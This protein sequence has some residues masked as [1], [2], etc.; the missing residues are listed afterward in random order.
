[1]TIYK[2]YREIKNLQKRGKLKLLDEK[3]SG[4]I[5]EESKDAIIKIIYNLDDFKHQCDNYN[6]LSQ[7]TELNNTH[8]K[9]L[10]SD[11]NL[12][13]L[14]IENLNSKGFIRL[15]K[16]IK[17]ISKMEKI[18]IIIKVLELLILYLN[19][20]IIYLDI[21]NENVMIH[22][23]TREIKFI[24]LGSIIYNDDDFELFTEN[25]NY[26]ILENEFMKNDIKNYNRYDIDSFEKCILYIEKIINQLNVI[27]NSALLIFND[28]FAECFNILKNLYKF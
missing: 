4:A 25:I 3:F 28:S 1:M 13:I 8:P 20:K 12:N 27:K 17:M 15:D 18:K 22:P 5:Y 24:D 16:Y 23:K 11:D 7:K 6:L 14:R 9:L 10:S 19:H 21:H 2:T 26:F